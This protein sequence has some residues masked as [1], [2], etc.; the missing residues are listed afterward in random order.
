MFQP[1]GLRGA[2]D[3]K[4][5]FAVAI[6]GG[7]RVDGIFRPGEE[8]AQR[9]GIRQR[10]DVPCQAVQPVF[11]RAQHFAP[12]DPVSLPFAHDPQTVR[13][14][15]GL[16]RGIERILPARLAFAPLVC[17]AHARVVFPAIVQIVQL[18][19]RLFGFQGA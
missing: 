18:A 17:A 12:G 14:L 4:R 6:H 9:P 15:G 3:G 13:R 2:R 7:N 16:R 11:A 1:I 8:F 10:T 19:V 5:A